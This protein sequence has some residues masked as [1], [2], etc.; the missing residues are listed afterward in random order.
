L[1]AAITALEKA[2]Q[3]TPLSERIDRHLVNSLKLSDHE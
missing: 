3:T 1:L 2:F